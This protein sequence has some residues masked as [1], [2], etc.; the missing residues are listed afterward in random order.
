MHCPSTS[1]TVDLMKNDVTILL[2]E[3]RNVGWELSPYL[4]GQELKRICDTGNLER[5]AAY[6]LG[7][8]R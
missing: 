8:W 4:P 2:D 5:A 7:I 6:Y 3:G 1:E